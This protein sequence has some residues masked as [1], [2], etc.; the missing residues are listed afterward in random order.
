MSTP[1]TNRTYAVLI[2]DGESALA[3]KVLRSLAADPSV[4]AHVLALGTH[5]PIRFSRHLAS[6][7]THDIETYDTRRIERIV[8][9]ARALG[10]DVILPVDVQTTR[11]L[12]LHRAEVERV[13]A[14][15]PL[16]D[17]DLLDRVSDKWLFSRLLADANAPHP[18]TILYDPNNPNEVALDKARYPVLAKARKSSNGRGIAR[19]E[20]PDSV[21]EYAR[22]RADLGEFCVQE[23]IPGYDLDCSV[24]ADR[25]TILAHTIQRGIIAARKPFM[26]P[27][28]IEFIHDNR[29]LRIVE[30]FVRTIGWSG[31][32][33]FDL[34]VDER[35]RRIVII[36]MNARY[37]TS[38]LGSLVAGVNFP[39]LACLTARGVRYDPPEYRDVRYARPEVSLKLLGEHYLR[40]D[41]AIRTLAETGLPFTYR[42]PLPDL[43]AQ[44][45]RVKKAI[46]SL[47]PESP[48]GN[49]HAQRRAA[50]PSSS[51]GLRS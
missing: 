7:H 43:Y 29:P 50:P 40:H 38:L 34:R 47:I 46:T 26:P 4:R 35:E 44:L 17:P 42:D 36:E 33:H 51:M 15:P 14:L 13:A 39:Q 8:D 10:V 49:H 24:L 32:A 22:S 25:G 30:S 19:C 12:S 1:N 31:V 11:L 21:R 6:F 48:F 45:T 20:T 3:L 28:A 37:W 41:S 5:A 2:P 18:Q 9:L 27:A 23:F 16:P